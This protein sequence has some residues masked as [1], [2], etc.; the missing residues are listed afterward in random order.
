M[1]KNPNATGGKQT[2]ANKHSPVCNIMKKGTVNERV[3]V[4]FASISTESSLNF[5]RTNIMASIESQSLSASLYFWYLA[6]SKNFSNGFESALR[7]G[8]KKELG[9]GKPHKARK[10]FRNVPSAS[11]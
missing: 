7:H 6:S 2:N 10:D 8:A 9:I 11:F 3:G 5:S 4:R 1:K